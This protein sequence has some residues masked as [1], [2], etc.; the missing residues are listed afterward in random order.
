MVLEAL[1]AALE[2]W[3]TEISKTGGFPL[4]EEHWHV[5]DEYL[6]IQN[7]LRSHIDAHVGESE[8]E[9]LFPPYARACRVPMRAY[10]QWSP[11]ANPDAISFES[12]IHTAPNGYR[13]TDGDLPQNEY[14]GINLALLDHPDLTSFPRIPDDQIDVHMIAIATTQPAPDL[15]HSLGDDGGD[16]PERRRLQRASRD[17]MADQIRRADRAFRSAEGREGAILAPGLGCAK[18]EAELA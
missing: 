7:S 13:P 16:G 15:D 5:G 11:R 17:A 4:T 12:I 6:R 3:Q 1:D 9:K 10:S 14:S 18:R 8:C 2:K